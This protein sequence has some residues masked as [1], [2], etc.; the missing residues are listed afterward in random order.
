MNWKLELI[1]I[2]FT[3]GS[4]SATTALLVGP[5]KFLTDSQIKDIPIKEKLIIIGNDSFK[6]LKI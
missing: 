5:Q 2:A 1:H 4:L 6:N 3:S